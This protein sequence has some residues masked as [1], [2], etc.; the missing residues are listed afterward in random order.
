VPARSAVCRLDQVNVEL[1]GSLRDA[2]RGRSAGGGREAG[3]HRDDPGSL[4][5]HFIEDR[6]RHLS[7]NGVGRRCQSG[8]PTFCALARH[9]LHWK[10]RR[11][12]QCYVR[13]WRRLVIFTSCAALAQTAE[14]SPSFEVASV[15]PAAPITGNMI[16][17]DARRP[18]EPGPWPDYVYQCHGEERSHECVWG[19]E[20]PDPDRAGWIPRDTIRSE[21][22]RG[23]TK[24]SS[25]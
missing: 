1:P 20:L 5:R 23:A 25:W 6:E 24:R 14:N 8:Q 13:S 19:E 17:W 10:Q 2:G 12:K 7:Q 4:S 22:A 16:R 11:F 3:E 18:R 15:K 9:R 21:T